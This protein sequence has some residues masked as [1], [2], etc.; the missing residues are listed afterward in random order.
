MI[1]DLITKIHDYCNIDARLALCKIYGNVF[2]RKKL[3]TPHDFFFKSKIEPMTR[4]K[5]V[6][7]VWITRT[8]GRTW[9]IK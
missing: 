5:L 1:F 7:G 3:I 2:I 9:I 4:I 6:N 8:M